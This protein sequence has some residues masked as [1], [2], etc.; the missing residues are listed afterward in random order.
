M[1]RF[2]GFLTILFVS[3]M[4]LQSTE[5]LFAQTE[6]EK[7]QKPIEIGTKTKLRVKYVKPFTTG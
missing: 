2:R 7:A 1:I 6:G 5:F 4:L 3:M